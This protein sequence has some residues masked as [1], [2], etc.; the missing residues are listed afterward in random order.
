[1]EKRRLTEGPI[2][3]TLIRL[4]IPIMATAFVQMAYNLMDMLWLG[5]LSTEAVAAAGT[6]GFFTWFGSALF[7]V[8]KIGAE[9]G[10]AQSF[11][12]NNIGAA[13][14]YVVTAFQLNSLIAII[15]SIILIVFLN[16]IVGFFNLGDLGVINM[17]KDYLFIVALGMLFYFTNPVMS[18]VYSGSGDPITPFKVNLVGLVI[19][20]ILDPALIFGLG[21]M[22]RMGIK[23]AAYAT[24]LAQFIVTMI[25]LFISLG[26]KELFTDLKFF[27]RMEREYLNRIVKLGTPPAIQ[28][29]LFASISM[30]IA[31]I[32]SQWGPTPIAVQKIGSQI[33]SIS[34]MTAEGFLTALSAFIGQNYGAGS[35]DR[36]KEGYKKGMMIV[37]SIGVFS[38]LLLFFFA[39]PVFKLFIPNDPEA[40]RM[41]ISYLKILS[42]SQFFLTIEVGTQ[43]AFNGIGRTIPPAVVAITFNSLRIPSALILSK[44]ALGL[45]G[46]WWSIS[47]S[48]VFKGSVLSLWFIKTLRTLDKNKDIRLS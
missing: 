29:G 8:S 27:R 12:K 3:G 30:L 10:V 16:P 18:G 42:L 40:L 21:P 36:V 11:G 45:N 47:I 43:G 38:T 33:E 37:G 5:R 22:P 35:L 1:M 46:V 44:T 14:K 19:N 24:V 28:S 34:W 17:T 32:I 4:A 2:T 41:G 39:E 25:F 13:K 26:K 15:Y 48:T 6:A 23:G 20:M 7:L 9:V 31:K